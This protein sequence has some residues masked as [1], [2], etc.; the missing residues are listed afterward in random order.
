MSATANKH[1]KFKLIRQVVFE[2]IYELEAVD[3]THA[4]RRL[5]RMLKDDTAPAPQQYA[6]RKG[7]LR[8]AD[9]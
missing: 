2:E 8:L 6:V 7:H 9:M 1:P 4:L 5:K 3:S